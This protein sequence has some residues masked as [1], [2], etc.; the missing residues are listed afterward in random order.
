[1]KKYGFTLVEVLVVIAIV[2]ILAAILLPALARARE[3]AYRV[4][5]ANNLKQMGLV[6]KMYSSEDKLGYLPPK[7]ALTCAG[8]IAAGTTIF[9]VAKVYPEYLTDL[10]SLVCPSSMKGLSPHE[11]WDQGE[12]FSSNWEA[13]P[14][15]N[16][17]IVEPCE[18][19]EHPYVYLGWMVEHSMTT[20]ANLPALTLNVESLL[21]SFADVQATPEEAPDIC[22]KD[23]PVTPGTGTV[24]S[25]HILRLREGL[26]RLLITNTLDRASAN[27]SQSEIP[28]M[29]DQISGDEPEHFNHVPGGCSVVY[30][31][32]HVEFLRYT[33][34]EADEFP[35]NPG[36]MLFHEMSHAVL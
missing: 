22:A 34:G 6:F 33:G 12:T 8:E 24:G 28:V 32:G 7:K 25:G 5:C 3:S 27:R 9:D 20:P 26:D 10:R 21:Q 1:M 2:G 23:W 31:D 14:L 16:N 4:S 15:S 29:W 30:L 36:G 35:C 18:V 17:G 13:G 11:L 19:T